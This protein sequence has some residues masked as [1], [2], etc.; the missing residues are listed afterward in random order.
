MPNLRSTGRPLL[1]GR[2]MIHLLNIF[3]MSNHG[4]CKRGGCYELGGNAGSSSGQ[5]RSGRGQIRNSVSH[6]VGSINPK[7]LLRLS[8][9][10]GHFCRSL[11]VTHEFRLCLHP[12]GM[13]RVQSLH[14]PHRR[15]LARHCLKPGNPYLL[16]ILP[17]TRGNDKSCLGRLFCCSPG[18][19]IS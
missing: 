17:Q 5:D 16:N 6:V 2:A 3:T 1:V 10:N 7:L 8:A 15:G 14:L 12:G 9:W 11:M 19:I 4:G 13:L 18:E